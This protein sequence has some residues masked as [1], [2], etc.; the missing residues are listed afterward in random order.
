VESPEQ[1]NTIFFKPKKRPKEA[2]FGLKKM[3]FFVRTW[4]EK[5]DP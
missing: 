1:K 5:P 4:N 2:L 3:V